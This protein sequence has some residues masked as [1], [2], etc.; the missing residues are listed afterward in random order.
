[1]L[2]GIHFFALREGAV[3]AEVERR[4]AD[5]VPGERLT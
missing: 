4:I 2:V 1:M 5:E 3:V